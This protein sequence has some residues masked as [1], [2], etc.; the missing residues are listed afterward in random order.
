MVPGSR[1][2][3]SEVVTYAFAEALR[4]ADHETLVVGYRRRGTDPPLH[5]DDVVADDR[6]IE[7]RKAGP[8]AAL[9]MAR[10]VGQHTP[11]TFAKFTSRRYREVVRKLFEERRVDAVIVD[12]AAMAW[13]R[14]RGN[15]APRWAYLA[16]NVEYRIYAAEARRG[17]ASGW[18]NAREARLLEVVEGALAGSADQVWTLCDADAATLA[19]MGAAGR[20][21]TFDLLPITIPSTPPPHGEVDVAILGTWTWSA[22]RAGLKWFLADVCPHLPP[23]LA[24][25]VAGAGSETLDRSAPGVTMRGRVPEVMPFLQ[26]ARVIAVPSVRGEGVQITTLDAIASGRPVVATPIAARGIDRLPPTVAVAEEPQEFAARLA[27]AVAAPV[28]PSAGQAARAWI[29]A[30][31]TAFQRRVAEAVDEL[32]AGS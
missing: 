2:T 25:E 23:S 17:G 20:T 12:H 3:G 18:A 5:P 11:Y 24:V 10:A 27:E 29:E 21:R 16:H 9:W 13:V 15:N 8:H 31:R 6:P 19:D 7:T 22:N 14:P 26:R 28:D 1:Q 32:V 30:R 4:A